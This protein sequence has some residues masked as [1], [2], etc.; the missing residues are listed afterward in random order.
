MNNFSPNKNVYQDMFI[1]EKD[2]WWYQGLR[3]N[4]KFFVNKYNHKVVLD[5]G[6][7]TGGNMIEI[8]SITKEIYGIDISKEAISIA[9]K[10]NIKNLQQGNL[11]KIPFEDKKFELIYCMD[12]FGNLNEE[13]TIRALQEFHRCLDE[14]GILIL[15]T[16]GIE[17]LTSAHDKY[18][19]IQKRYNLNELVNILVKTNFEIIKKT[20]RHFFLFP[21]IASIKILNKN[22]DISDSG[23]FIKLPRF[24]NYILY[25]TMKMEN[26]LLRFINYPIGSS[27][28][29]IAK[30]R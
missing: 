28:F 8:S 18:W 21:I 19:D 12:V 23:D 6:C 13:D 2:Y 29:I 10:H 24:V 20:Y 3:N 7:G 17:S 4:L 27:L 30:K 26:F 11:I 16:A 15:Q 5:A 25:L 1:Y 22:K 14:K 9:K